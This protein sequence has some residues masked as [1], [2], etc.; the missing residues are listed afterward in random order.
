LVAAENFAQ[1][2]RNGPQIEQ[3]VVE[4][5]DKAMVRRSHLE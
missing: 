1:Q 2:D 5:Q 4:G 3:K